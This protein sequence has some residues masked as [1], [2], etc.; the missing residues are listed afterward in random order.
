MFTLTLPLPSSP[1]FITLS[2][3]FVFLFVIP[4]PFFAIS[5][6]EKDTGGNPGVLSLGRGKAS[7]AADANFTSEIWAT[8]I[9]IDRCVPSWSVLK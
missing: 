1:S 8:D 5:G 3:P 7:D 4:F 6:N 9:V 2:S